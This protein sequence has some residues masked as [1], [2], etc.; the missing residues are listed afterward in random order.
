MIS[1]EDVKMYFEKLGV[2]AGTV[3]ALFVAFQTGAIPSITS[4]TYDQLVVNAQ[5]IAEEV[6]NGQAQD[7]SLKIIA[8]QH[9]R[10]MAVLVISLKQICL[11]TAKTKE[12]AADCGEMTKN[13]EPGYS[14]S[15]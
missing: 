12:S 11:N 1:I 9:T 7:A 10:Q 15:K 5:A 3:L 13:L 8:E 6:K 4:K 2:P 14:W